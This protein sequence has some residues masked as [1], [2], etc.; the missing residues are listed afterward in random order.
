MRFVQKSGNSFNP[1]F[2]V[3]K[4]YRLHI[5]KSTCSYVD[6]Q[7]DASEV[8]IETKFNENVFIKI[9]SGL[10]IGNI[11]THLFANQ[12]DTDRSPGSNQ[13]NDSALCAV[14]ESISTEFLPCDCM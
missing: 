6:Q 14:I 5:Y 13:D 1:A 2:N 7:L 12:A 8:N 3:H 10:I 4:W 11:W 9:K